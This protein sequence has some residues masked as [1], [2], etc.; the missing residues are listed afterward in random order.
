MH[1]SNLPTSLFT[2]S[3]S[4]RTIGGGLLAKGNGVLTDLLALTSL[5][6]IGRALTKV[7][8]GDARLELPD[9]VAVAVG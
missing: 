7:N 2:L 9:G 1:N 3:Q 4:L 6:S 5:Q 8:N